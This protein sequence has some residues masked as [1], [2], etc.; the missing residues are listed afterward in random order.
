M[1][2]AA[3]ELSIYDKLSET[4]DLVRQTGHQC[5]MSE[6]AIEKFITQLLEKN[7]PLRGPPQY[8]LLIAVYKVLATLGLILFTAYFVIQPFSPLPHE[9]VLSGAHTWRSLV[10][11]IRLMSLPMTK[12]YMPETK[13]APLHGGDED[14]CFPDGN[15]MNP[16]SSVIKGEHWKDFDLWTND[17]EQNESDLIPAN[18]TGCAQKLPLKVVLL[19]DTPKKFEGLHPLV[20]KTEQ[21]L[22]SEELQHFLCQYP[23]ATEG[24]TEGFFAKWWRCFPDRWFPFPYPW[25]RPLNRSHILREL[26]PVFTDLPFPEDAS[27]KKCFLLQPEPIVGSKMHRMH[28]LFTIG[29]GEAMLQLI[30][31]FQCRRHC[32][33]VAMPLESGDIGYAGA[34]HWKVY[35]IARGVQPLVICDATAVSEP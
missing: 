33:S 20:I 8:P 23:E 18:C 25:R 34:T 22:S 3:N 21:S 1:D 17:H 15:K 16:W 4:V 2:L 24:F 11:H 5:G 31:P 9:P 19:E 12:K 29:N 6:K 14:R 26:F 10:H 32:H 28:D 13:G 35:I 7:E 27:L 30:P